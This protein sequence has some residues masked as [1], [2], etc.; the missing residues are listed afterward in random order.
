MDKEAER[1]SNFPWWLIIVI[2]G[3]ILGYLEY[4]K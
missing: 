2:I 1:E 4:K 3:I